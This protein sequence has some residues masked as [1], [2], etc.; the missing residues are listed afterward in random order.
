LGY[1]GQ[2]FFLE[3]VRPG[4]AQI[5]QREALT[6]DM[7]QWTGLKPVVLLAAA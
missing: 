5:A 6:L 1:V 3:E 2:L 4:H 7:L